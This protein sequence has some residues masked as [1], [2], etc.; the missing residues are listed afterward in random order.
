[1]YGCALLPPVICINNIVI[2]N[3]EYNGNQGTKLGFSQSHL[4]KKENVFVSADIDILWY[5]AEIRKQLEVLPFC[6]CKAESHL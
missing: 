5:S 4:L 6:L 1:M 2:L 3:N